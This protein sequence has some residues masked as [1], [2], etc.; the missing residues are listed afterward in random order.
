MRSYQAPTEAGN[1]DTATKSTCFKG[2]SA[3]KNIASDTALLVK[4]TRNNDSRNNY[5]C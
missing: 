1:E 5:Q 2:L 3:I 4:T